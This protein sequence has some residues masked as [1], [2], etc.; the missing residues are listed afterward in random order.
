MKMTEKEVHEITVK[1]LEDLINATEK[2]LC[3]MKR[4]LK[5]EKV[6]CDYFKEVEVLNEIAKEKE[7][8]T[9]IKDLNN[10]LTSRILNT[11]NEL[12]NRNSDDEEDE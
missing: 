1:K 7:S 4:T 9:D 3:E 6:I 8:N 12:L 2:S 10:A 5:A 11:W